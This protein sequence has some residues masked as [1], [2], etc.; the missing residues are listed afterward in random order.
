MG[1]TVLK[2]AKDAGLTLSELASS[3]KGQYYANKYRVGRGS[4]RAITFSAIIKVPVQA[5]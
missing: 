3:R 2:L 5:E 1:R 4:I